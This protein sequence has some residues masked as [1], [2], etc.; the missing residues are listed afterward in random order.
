MIKKLSIK[1]AL[2]MIGHGNADTKI[3][4]WLVI[5]EK[6]TEA[7][8]RFGIVDNRPKPEQAK[9]YKAWLEGEGVVPAISK[10]QA[11]RAAALFKRQEEIIRLR[12][13]NLIPE[14]WSNPSS[15]LEGMDWVKAGKDPI[16]EAERR[17]GREAPEDRAKLWSDG[18]PGAFFSEG[19][20]FGNMMNRLP[21]MSKSD[22][23]KAVGAFFGDSSHTIKCSRQPD[24]SIR[25]I[26]KSNE[27]SP[28]DRA[29]FDITIT[30]HKGVG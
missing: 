26:E 18:L 19:V 27:N 29:K 13:R 25:V 6:V 24:G 10:S 23:L 11:S 7:R 14:K 20:A 28:V 16:A 4:G 22:Q 17:R 9:K 1:E 2:V 21:R 3:N 5:G 8:G 12:R 15:L 30:F